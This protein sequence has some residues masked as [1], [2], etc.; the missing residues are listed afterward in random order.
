VSEAVGILNDD[1]AL[2]V[3]KKSSLASAALVQ[4][5]KKTYDA[6]LQLTS[7]KGV[8]IPATHRH[9]QML[10]LSV[11]S[12][13]KEEPVG[14]AAAGGGAEKLVTHMIDGMVG[15][16]HDEDV[17]DEHKKE[18]CHNETQV[19]HSIEDQ[20]K[21]TIEQTSTEIAEQEDQL[22]TTVAEIKA[23][24]EKIA[25]LDKMV[26]VTTEQRKS[27]H[28]EFVD[29]FATSA[30][31]LRLIDKA[32]KRLE[33]FYMPEKHAAAKKA[34]T[35][36][37]LAKAG[38][39]LLH[40]GSESPKA[41]PNLVAKIA[42]K[43]L[44]EGFDALVQL[45]EHTTT[46][47]RF[48]SQVRNG[49]D[50]VVIPETPKTYEKKES[51]GVMGLMN[52]FKTDLKM[53]MTESET[54]EKFM[55]KEYVRI[56]NDAQ[57]TRNQDVKSLNEKKA[58]KATLDQKL[59]DNRAK[60]ALTEEELH[61][62]QLYLVQLHTECDFLMRNFDVRHE[63]RID[64]ETGLESAETIVTHDEPP[65]H[66]SIEKQFKEE[67]TDDDVDEHFPGTPIDDGPDR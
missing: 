61:N 25:Y 52:D 67:K 65:S 60:L 51:G 42:N 38:L 35:D 8:H 6:L 15:V 44:P 1:D 10:L 66:R 13:T 63:G 47:V 57:E 12:K 23:L 7:K 14:E 26:H 9:R 2:E 30:T 50:P 64:E 54:E 17:G 5:P 22:A 46:E 43:L 36:A 49:V 48:A 4:Q 58:A 40:K 33:K 34:A 27:E 21:S 11:V 39:S 28:Q 16:L 24:T 29:S 45:H 53:D 62:L 37:A 31:A 55:A 59:V 18:W 3:F 32:V 41:D 19:A 56:M 20:K